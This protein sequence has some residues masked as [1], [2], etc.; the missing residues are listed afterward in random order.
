M[1]TDFGRQT[2]SVIV[3]V[4]P[5]GN[6]ATK[7]KKP[8]PDHSLLCIIVLPSSGMLIGGFPYSSG[9]RGSK[10]L[11]CPIK[12]EKLHLENTRSLGNSAVPVNEIDNFKLIIKE[13]P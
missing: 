6:Q 2:G 4:F 3:F 12:T 8:K 5:L 7:A 11:S 10:A 9:G 1:E 13:L